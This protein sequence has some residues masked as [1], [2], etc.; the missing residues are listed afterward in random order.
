ME[1]AWI[2]FNANTA[3]FMDVIFE[4]SCCV[5]QKH[6]KGEKSPRTRGAKSEGTVVV[7]G[8]QQKTIPFPIIK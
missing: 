5:T 8:D 4:T 1:S 3:V 2:L 6:V 7:K